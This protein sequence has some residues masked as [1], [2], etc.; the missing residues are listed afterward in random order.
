M[1]NRS[2][3]VLNVYYQCQQT[4]LNSG[5]AIVKAVHTPSDNVE[6]LR[7][8]VRSTQVLWSAVST[9]VL[10]IGNDFVF[11]QTQTQ[12][13]ICMSVSMARVPG[14]KEFVNLVRSCMNLGKNLGKIFCKLS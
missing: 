9:A 13:S 14:T 1:K 3:A 2:L 7:V 8:L 10:V 5:K 11:L 4:K 6:F 12:V